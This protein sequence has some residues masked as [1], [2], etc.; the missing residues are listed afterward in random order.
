MSSK[1]KLSEL[2]K[3]ANVKGRLGNNPGT[4]KSAKA[5]PIEIELEHGRGRHIGWIAFG[6][7]LGT[8]FVLMLGSIGQYVGGLLLLIALLQ[9]VSA[10]RTFMHKPGTFHV[11]EDEISVPTG[12]C[13]GQ[14]VSLT[15]SQL[16]HAFFLRRAVPW[17]KAGPIL[18]VEAEGKAYSY[19]RDWFAS[20]SDQRRVATALHHRLASK[21]VA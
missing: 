20:D 15:S 21:E 7:V 4:G 17:S 5:L 19:P 9:A 11:T 13:S 18:V 1:A 10:A 16:Q 12:L 6:A 3:K 2:V 14:Q 8:L